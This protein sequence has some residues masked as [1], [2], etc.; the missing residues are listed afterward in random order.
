MT[1]VHVL[2]VAAA[3]LTLSCG[4][5]ARLCSL[6][7]RPFVFKGTEVVDH[8]AGLLC[9]SRGAVFKRSSSNYFKARKVWIEALERCGIL[10]QNRIREI[11]LEGAHFIDIM[12][13][14]FLGGP[15]ALEWG[16][17]FRN[18]IY[19]TDVAQVIKANEVC[20]ILLGV[21]WRYFRGIF[22]LGSF[23]LVFFEIE[24]CNKKVTRHICYTG[25]DSWVSIYSLTPAHFDSFANFEQL[26]IIKV[27]L[28]LDSLQL[29]EDRLWELV[30]F[31]L[32]SWW[33]I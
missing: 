3:N 10:L 1:Y 8:L 18:L 23:I 31:C 33:A 15:L 32:S 7:R 17:S 20:L 6:A 2:L 12:R 27:S 29:V 9:L 22:R 26:C 14:N 28:S 11:V 25:T 4:D 16:F 24:L 21:F 30:H 19:R 5:L 13:L